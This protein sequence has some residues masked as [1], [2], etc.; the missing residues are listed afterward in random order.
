MIG[1]GE[2]YPCSAS[3]KNTTVFTRSAAEA[4]P[5]FAA[6]VSA[7]GGEGYGGDAVNL[8]L[9]RLSR[10]SAACSKAAILI[11]DSGMINTRPR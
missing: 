11:F 1:I 2:A 3:A 10:Y 8:P 4:A 5:S 7:N 6:A 9:S